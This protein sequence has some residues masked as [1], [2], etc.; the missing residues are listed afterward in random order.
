MKIGLLASY[1]D[2]LY[3]MTYLNKFNIEYDIYLD[4]LNGPYPDKGFGFS[5]ENI[6]RGI[7]YLIN[8]GVQKVIIPP[9]YELY[10]SGDNRILPI[11]SNYLN[12]CLQKSLVGK[13]GF[14]GDISDGEKINELFYK[15]SSNYKLGSNQKN[16]KKFNFPFNIWFKQV[17]LW[18][19]FLYN[20][21]FKQDLVNKTVKTD[22]RYFK[23][24]NVDTVIPLNYG[25]FAFSKTIKNFLNT[26]KIRFHGNSVL[27]QIIFEVLGNNGNK[28]Y[29]IN[30]H[31]NGNIQIL[32]NSKKR[33][34][35]IN[36]GKQSNFNL[37]YLN[38]E[39]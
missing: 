14:I 36:R 23:D 34:W 22:I 8:K 21:G 33:N 38:L 7:N 18:K 39:L 37:F 29:N 19:Y 10:L 26:K 32:I 30:I 17:N 12:F 5:L 27:E 16:I 31:Y 2:D 25:Y 20:L 13:L 4:W 24:A 9:I 15:F 28:K 11:F 35:I 1:F 6:N 3:I